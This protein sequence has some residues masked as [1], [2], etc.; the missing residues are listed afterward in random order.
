M[1]T[2]A[3]F[4]AE[5]GPA[6]PAGKSL[7][8]KLTA[9]VSKHPGMAIGIIIILV[10]IILYFYAQQQGLFGL[11][12]GLGG[13]KSGGKSGSKSGMAG[14]DKKSVRFADQNENDNVEDLIAAINDE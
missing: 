13:G 12:G 5:A 1:S 7:P 2:P 9:A 3:E 11:G 10:V 8:A 14:K 4:A 6:A